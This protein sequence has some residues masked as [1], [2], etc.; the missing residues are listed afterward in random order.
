MEQI[1]T[2]RL[3]NRGWQYLTSIK[4]SGIR[5]GNFKNAI[6]FSSKYKAKNIFNEIKENAECELYQ[7]M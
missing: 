7:W 1:W 4:P 3:K 6:T 5:W 2:I